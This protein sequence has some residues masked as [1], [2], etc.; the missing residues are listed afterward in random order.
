MP[1]TE[2]AASTTP[3]RDLFLADHQR[4]AALLMKLIAAF[5]A[6]DRED[7]A[8]LWTEL[9]SGLLAHLEAEE[10]IMIPALVRT[11]ARDARVILEEHRHIRSRLAELGVAVDLHTIRVDTARDFID[12]LRAH[13]EN[14]DRLMY[15]WVEAHFA[16]PERMSA[17]SE[18]ASRLRARRRMTAH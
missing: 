2:P 12:E 16:E 1:T 6:N 13:A 14:E 11:C 5:E 10:A 8:S 7:V 9:E 17:L 3:V 4:L 18:L 15:R